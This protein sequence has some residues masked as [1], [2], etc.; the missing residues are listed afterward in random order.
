MDSRLGW[1]AVLALATSSPVDAR[2]NAPIGLR[3]EFVQSTPVTAI[4][5]GSESARAIVDTAAGDADGE[6]TLTKEVIARSGGVRLGKAVMRDALGREFAPERFRIPVVEIDGQVFRG[7]RAVQAVE[8][9]DEGAPPVAN[10][11]G[12]HFLSRFLVVVDFANATVT[13]WP[14]GQ[15]E[16]AAVNCGDTR[17]PMVATKEERLAVSEFVMDS[18][19]V[20][21]AWGTASSYSLLTQA[22]ADRLDLETVQRAPDS[23]AFFESKRFSVAD[24]DFGSQDFVVLPVMLTPDFEGTIGR[25]F[26]DRHVVCFDYRRREIRVR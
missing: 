14:A 7:V 8:R 13:L 10:V 26:F 24:R 11:I 2:E 16:Q 5:I 18:R 23:P 17:I 9:A 4:K 1:L 25:D 6:L 19:R 3:I 20:R 12:K 21:L 22:S 15:H